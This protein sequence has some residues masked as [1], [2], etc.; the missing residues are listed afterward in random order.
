LKLPNIGE[1]ETMRVPAA[2]S[3]VAPD[4]SAVRVLLGLTGGTMAHFELPAGGVSRAIAHRTVEEVWLT[5]SGRGELWRKQGAREEVVALE[6]GVCVSLPRGT[7]F[8]FRA[9]TTEALTIV[10]ATIPRWP[11]DG[12][13]EFVPGPWPPSLTQQPD[14]TAP[15]G[16]R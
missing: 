4:G 11:G 1:F 3:E 5:L 6:T 16:T 7:H 13:A 10:A 14:S 8:Q 15:A 9:S 12:E 2:P